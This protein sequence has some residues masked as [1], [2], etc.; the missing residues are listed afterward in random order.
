MTDAIVTDDGVMADLLTRATPGTI[1]ANKNGN[2]NH[3][4][5]RL[6]VMSQ[7]IYARRYPDTGEVAISK[8]GLKLLC[9]LAKVQLSR[10][11]ADMKAHGCT[12]EVVD[13]AEGT[14][15]QG[16]KVLCF[17]VKIGTSIPHPS[18]ERS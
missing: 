5:D 15:L 4:T 11:I 18:K 10:A 9:T 13:L 7:Q 14:T 12:E 6:P 8:A 2:L 17:V 3:S 16:M 1:V